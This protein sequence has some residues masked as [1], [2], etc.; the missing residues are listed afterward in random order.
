MLFAKYLLMYRENA[1]PA[2]WLTTHITVIGMLPT[3]HELTSLEIALFTEWF[4]TVI[5]AVGMHLVVISLL[6]LQSML[7]KKKRKIIYKF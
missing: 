5:T 6:F 7:T 2:E 1:F 3:K 4:I